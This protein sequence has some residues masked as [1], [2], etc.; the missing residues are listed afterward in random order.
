M[1]VLHAVG[2]ALSVT[3]SMTWEILWALILGFALTAVIQALVRRST[4]ERAL[5]DDR[6]RTLAL[7]T[8][9]GVASS[10]CSYAAVALARTLVR[11]GSGFSAAMVFEIASTNLVVELGIVLAVL[12]GWQF[13][14]AEF[15]GGPIMI[16]VV[17][18]W[19]RLLLRKE[20]LDAARRQASA[21]VAGVMEGHAAMDMGIADAGRPWRRIRSR[22]AL[23]S[24]SHIFVMEW[25][26]VLRDMAVGL[27]VAGALAAWVPNS[28]VAPLLLRRPPP[29]V[30]GDGP[31][32]RSRGRDRQL[33]VLDRQRPAG[34]GAVE[35]R[36]QLRRRRGVHLRRPA[37]R[38]DP[39]HLPPVL[40]HAHDAA[41]HGGLL[42]VDGE[43][44]V[45]GRAHLRRCRPRP[46]R[47]A[48]HRRRRCP[49]L[50]RHHR[51][52]HHLPGRGR[53]PR[54][55]LRPH[56]GRA[57]AAHDGRARTDRPRARRD[58]V[59]R[60]HAFV[61]G[62]PAGT[63]A[64]ARWGPEAS[65]RVNLQRMEAR[66][67]L[68][69]GVDAVLTRRGSPP[70]GPVEWSF[71]DRAGVLDDAEAEEDPATFVADEIRDLRR[72][73]DAMTAERTALVKAE[74]FTTTSPRSS[75]DLA[76]RIQAE[77]EASEQTEDGDRPGL[78]E[79]ARAAALLFYLE[80]TGRAPASTRRNGSSA[81]SATA[82]A[83]AAAFEIAHPVRVLGV[84]TVGQWQATTKVTLALD[85]TLSA[86]QVA[87]MWQKVRTA[88]L[89]QE[90]AGDR[91]VGSQWRWPS[92]SPTIPDAR[93]RTSAAPGTSST[94]TGHSSRRT[95]AGSATPPWRRAATSSS[96]PSSRTSRAA[97]GSGCTAKRRGSPREPPTTE[98]RPRRRGRAF[99]GREGPQ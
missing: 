93:G 26:A 82:A 16:V 38:P 52:Q 21:G 53:R 72:E 9:L 55:P 59:R 94:R 20:V 73:V 8:G 50:G 83:E 45:P 99:V 79:R 66:H 65:P 27:L 89:R 31:P 15:V 36:H 75:A 40:R 11:K 84:T 33:R 30:R 13:T 28:V 41:H 23:T 48:R 17:A 87:A 67:H 18:L 32:G 54:H 47:P 22:R 63:R 19:F 85:P 88:V 92:S 77:L 69:V 95:S 71:L 24:V 58:P 37:H 34:R 70:A 42:P 96:G 86:A 4:I 14:A 80:R 68:R 56:W 12:L 97:S 81:S 46:D 91:S 6:P 78:W 3:G 1:R 90:R 29:A 98:G 76:S 74:A 51:P 35:R 2:H 61:G 10:S 39:G 25:A 49:A 62:R 43:R 5:G 44:R 60:R 64:T 57:H 7:A